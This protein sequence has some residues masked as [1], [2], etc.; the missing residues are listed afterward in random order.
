MNQ[1]LIRCSNCLLQGITQTLGAVL[2]N[3]II[4]IQRF[5]KN[6]NN[7]YRDY[8]II[9][10]NNFTI[11]CGKCGKANYAIQEGRQYALMFMG[12]MGLHWGTTQMMTGTIGSN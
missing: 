10:G 11:T 12:T 8:T 7:G 2:P 4:T 9:T 1:K 5:L 3:G 6:N